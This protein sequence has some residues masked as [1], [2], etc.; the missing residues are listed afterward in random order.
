MGSLPNLHELEQIERRRDKRREREMREQL[1]RETSRERERFSQKKQT[2]LTAVAVSGSGSGGGGGGGNGVAASATSGLSGL[3]TA[4]R[5]HGHTVHAPHRNSLTN[6]RHRV[7]RARSSGAAHNLWDEQML[8]HFSTCSPISTRS[9]R[10]NPVTSYQIQA[11]LAASRRRESINSSIGATSIRRLITLNNRNCRHKVP[12]HVRQKVCKCFTFLTIAHGLICAI[13]LPIF[14]LQGS[15]SIWHHREQWLQVGPNIGS[16]LLSVCMLVSAG[17]CLITPKL[18]RKFGYTVLIGVNYA[19]ICAFLMCHLYPS[20]YTLLPA[21]ICLGLTHSPAW[22]SKIAVVVHYGSKLSCSQH[23]CTLMPVLAVDAWEEHKLFCSRDQ[24]VRRLARWFQIAKD[25]GII[26]GAV[27]SSVILSCTSNDWNCLDTK[28]I[29]SLISTGS[30][31]SNR[32]ASRGIAAWQGW[33]YSTS[34]IVWNQQPGYS[35]EYYILNEHGTRICGADQCP[36]WHFDINQ[37]LYTPFIK[38]SARA[39]GSILIIIYLILAAIS[40]LLTILM[41]K[42]QATFRHERLKGI[43]DS[44]LFAGPLAYFVGTEQGYILSDFLRAFVSC[45]L[46]ISMVSGAIVAMG[47]MQAI[48]SCTLSMLLRH[49]KRIVII[50]A[51]FFFHSCLLLAL[52]TWKPSSDDSALFYVLAASWGACNGIWETLLLALVTLNHTNHVAEVTAPLQSLRFLGLAVTF[53]AHGFMCETP[54]IITLVVILMLSVPPYAMLEIRL[55]TQRK[56]HMMNL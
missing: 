13:L 11:A 36:I 52:S 45:S 21:Y 56:A 10:I 54:K 48:V 5:Y 6:N 19:T 3:P 53:A 12:A 25:L 34:T 9:H 22:V 18:I 29:E 16:L 30:I 40:L 28:Q 27:I 2:Y 33:P 15:N 46:G 20:I 39:G 43:T 32:S 38:E 4:N 24:K 23:E 31:Q 17:I 1:A 37:T 50:L 35:N 26:F 47:I 42:I 7:I 41:G 51:A 49:T 44:L 14:G 8:E 55:E